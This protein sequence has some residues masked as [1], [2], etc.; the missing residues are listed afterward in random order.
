MKFLQTN[1]G[2]RLRLSHEVAVVSRQQQNYEYNNCHA[3]TGM[4]GASK[5]PAPAGAGDGR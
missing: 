2:A 1:A 3:T 5:S 4:L